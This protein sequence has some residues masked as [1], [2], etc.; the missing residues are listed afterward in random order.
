ML[1]PFVN[2]LQ[3]SGAGTLALKE[4]FPGRRSCPSGLQSGPSGSR[5]A[6]VTSLCHLPVAEVARLSPAAN[7]TDDMIP[8]EFHQQEISITSSVFYESTVSAQSTSTKEGAKLGG[9]KKLLTNTI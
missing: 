1:I 7:R 4:S 5:L 6:F 8:V 3:I 9:G 2:F